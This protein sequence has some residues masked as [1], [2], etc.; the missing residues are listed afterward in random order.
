M[1][2]Y[3]IVKWETYQHYK[4]RSPPW[5]K[6][7]RDILASRTWVGASNETRV[8][9]I[10]SMVLAAATNNRIPADP[11][12]IRRVAYLDTIPDFAP[13]VKLGFL[14]IIE[15][16]GAALA[17]ASTMLADARP[18]K[19]R[20]E[21]E[22]RRG[23]HTRAKKRVVGGY[24]DDF[25][26]FWKAYPPLTGNPKAPAWAEWQRA[27][28]DVDPQTIIAAAKRYAEASS[29]PDAPKV[30]HARTWLHQKRW[31]DWGGPECGA[32]TPEEREA[33][34]RALYETAVR[35]F[36]APGPLKGSW[37]ES[38][39]GPPPGAPGCRVPAEILAAHGPQGG[40]GATLVA[41][42][43]AT[44]P[45]APIFEQMRRMA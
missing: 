26:V 31:N 6:L 43:S 19:R 7:H 9:A 3:R 11:D 44:A 39:L 20:E 41:A 15:E 34:A 24:S 4:D 33:D 29:K 2:F 13:L 35:R 10:A 30:A 42:G 38:Y 8:L 16:N 12:Y 22:E 5:I 28:I 1:A 36:Y 40:G 14:E 37:G 17:D 25:Q 32:K 45:G 18:E 21:T 27:V 23:E